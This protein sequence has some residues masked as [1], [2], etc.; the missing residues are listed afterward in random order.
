MAATDDSERGYSQRKHGQTTASA[1]QE[2]ESCAA[3]F[4]CI[5]AGNGVLL[6]SRRRKGLRRR[7]DR[8]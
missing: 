5:R 8:R 2:Q 6:L 4:G 1:K 7:M 3:A